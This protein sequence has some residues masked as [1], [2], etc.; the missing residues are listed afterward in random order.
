MGLGRKDPEMGPQPSGGEEPS[1]AWP[2]RGR[3][4]GQW[5]GG[6]GKGT[7]DCSF[8]IRGLMSRLRVSGDEA[9]EWGAG[10]QGTAQ[11]HMAGSRRTLATWK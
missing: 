4:P 6:G 11:G 7:L 10:R 5:A 8:K 2:A 9:Q 1:P 3:W